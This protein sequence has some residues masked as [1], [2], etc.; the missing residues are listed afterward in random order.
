[1]KGGYDSDTMNKCMTFSKNK[2]INDEKKI[3]FLELNILSKNFIWTFSHHVTA[4]LKLYI[5]IQEVLLLRFEMEFEA[6][7]KK[8]S[9]LTTM[10]K[11]KENVHVEAVTFSI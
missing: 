3:I 4:V 8:E 6:I 7:V 2:E 5:P 11:L 9:Q 1:M 10:L